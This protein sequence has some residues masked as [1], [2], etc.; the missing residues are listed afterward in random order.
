LRFGKAGLAVFAL[1]VLALLVSCKKDDQQGLTLA[2]STSVQPFAEM[3]AE[4]YMGEHREKR[5]I[6]QGGGSTAGIQ[7][8]REGACEIGMVSRALNDQEN[9]LKPTVIARDGIAIIVHPSNSVDDLTLVQVRNIFA[10]SIT[11]WS[12]VGGKAGGIRPLTREAGSGTR[13]AFV[14]LVMHKVEIPQR[15]MVQG[16]NGSIREVVANDPGSIGYISLGL[17]NERVK[18][19]HIEGVAPTHENV[20]AG[21]YKLVRPFLFVLKAAPSPA[22]S[23]FIDYMLSDG[24]QALLEKQGLIRAK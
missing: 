1:G 3:V 11:D 10:G 15:L 6:V 22:A 2:G 18:G 8:V 16:S 21:K 17:V 5:V 24:G 9:D 7:A 19:L 14:E 23:E 12:R 20:V 13:G 4:H